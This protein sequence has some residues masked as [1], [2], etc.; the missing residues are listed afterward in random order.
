MQDV[1]KIFDKYNPKKKL[2][3]SVAFNDMIADIE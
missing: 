2:S 3:V 1:Y